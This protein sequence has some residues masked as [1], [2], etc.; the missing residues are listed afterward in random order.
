MV[1]ILKSDSTKKQKII[2]EELGISV[3]TVQRIMK[4]LA[5]QGKIE[6]KGGKRFGYWEIHE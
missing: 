3:A 2:A 6:R 5:E 1:G 4:R